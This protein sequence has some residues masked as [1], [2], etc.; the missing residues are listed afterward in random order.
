MVVKGRNS[1]SLSAADSGLWILMLQ[2]ARRRTLDQVGWL[3]WRAAGSHLGCTFAR[4]HA[5]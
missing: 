5:G 2:L 1:L 4:L 3:D